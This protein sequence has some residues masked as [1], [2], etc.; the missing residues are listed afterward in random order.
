MVDAVVSFVVERTGD[1]LIKKAALLS[2]VKDEV[3][4]LKKELEWM[5]CFTKDAEEKQAGNSMIEQWVSDIREIAYDFEDVLDEFKLQVG[6]KDEEGES[7]ER[8]RGFFTAIGKSVREKVTTYNIGKKIE[9]LKKKLSD[10]SRRCELYGLRDINIKRDEDSHAVRR[11]KQLRRTTSFSLEVNVVGYQD[12]IKKL[13]DKLLDNEP[14]RYV[15]SIWGTGGLGKTTLAG[16]LYKS[17][18]IKQK[19]HYSAWVS[20]SQQYQLGDLLRKII[21]SFGFSVEELERMSEEDLGD[22]VNKSLQGGKYLVVIDD[23]WDQGA[24]RTLRK[25]FPDNENGSRVIITTR[26]KDDAELSDERTFVHKLRFLKS[27]ESWQLFYDKAFWNSSPEGEEQLM[28][29]REM[30]EKCRGLPLA[31]VVLGGLL[32]T[33][34]LREWKSVRKKMWKKLSAGSLEITYLLDL[35][36]DDLPYQL[37]L[38][39]LYLSQFPEDSEINT[40]RLIRLWEAEGFIPHSEE[41][42]EDEARNYLNELINRSLIQKEK[43][44]LG[45]VVTCRIHDLLRELTIRKATELNFMHIYDGIENSST[46]SSRQP[47]RRQVY[48]GMKGTMCLRQCTPVLR[49]LLLFHLFEE[50]PTPQKFA[51]TLCKKFRFLRVLEF[52]G[53]PRE[54][55][56]SLPKNIDKLVHLKYLG[57]RHTCIKGIPKSILNMSNLETLVLQDDKGGEISLQGN[58]TRLKNLR[59]LIGNFTKYCL[60]INNMTN[61]QTL[62]SSELCNFNLCK[63]RN[64]G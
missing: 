16:K 35:S 59:H 26:S 36:F 23:V 6:D 48:S 43:T 5:N 2:G 47:C 41:I 53:L 52:D 33:K 20:V 51:S 18:E 34:N 49:S 1:Y 39:F 24:W 12:E 60:C 8:K 42:M 28:L 62:Q 38:C 3:E 29:G 25:A 31:I 64:F 45:K 15:I 4:S 46:H 14:R 54:F 9:S 56:F 11:M 22:H 44:L 61:L 19:F 21:K 50:G 55:D 27:D 37:K 58:L 7:S 17:S 32:S 30:V 10:V 63:S 13:L 40:D 57:L